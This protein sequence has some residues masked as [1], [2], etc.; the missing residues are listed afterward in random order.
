MAREGNR[1]TVD[2]PS[3]EQSARGGRDS[4]LS[5]SPHGEFLYRKL[6]FERLGDFSMRVDGSENGG[7]Y[8]WYPEGWSETR[9][10][11]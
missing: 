9:K 6:G 4:G 11:K 8:I 2:G 1:A 10:A 5:A 3:I 7:I